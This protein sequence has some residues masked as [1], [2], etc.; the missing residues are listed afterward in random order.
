MLHRSRSHRGQGLAEYGL[1]I[2]MILGI[3]VLV[4]PTIGLGYGYIN[5]S[6]SS[7]INSAIG[8]GGDNGGGGNNPTPTPNGAAPTGYATDVSV[9]NSLSYV[10]GTHWDP[11]ADVTVTYSGTLLGDFAVG[12]NGDSDAYTS[13]YLNLTD[14]G[15]YTLLFTSGTKSATYTVNVSATALP[16]ARADDT[17]VGGATNLYAGDFAPNANITVTYTSGPDSGQ[18]LGTFQVDA[19]GGTTDPVPMTVDSHL[20]PGDYNLL[21]SAGSQTA[22]TVLGIEAPVGSGGGTV[23][24]PVPIEINP[25]PGYSEKITGT[26]FCPGTMVQ[27]LY[28]GNL[29]GDQVA[30]DSSGNVSISVT[31]PSDAVGGSDHTL[32]LRGT[33]DCSGNSGEVTSPGVHIHITIADPCSD[34][35]TVMTDYSPSYPI[36]QAAID[37]GGSGQITGQYQITQCADSRSLVRVDVTMSF[38]GTDLSN[39]VESGLGVPMPGDATTTDVEA[40]FSTCTNHDFT[41]APVVGTVAI[42]TDTMGPTNYSVAICNDRMYPIDSA[43]QEVSASIIGENTGGGYAGVVH[44]EVSYRSW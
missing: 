39:V 7:A 32:S 11:N 37:Q 6:V 30:A 15:S 4:V 9:D 3:M 10:S 40:N 18:A 38:S 20:S 16:W 5:S 26:G 14:V 19:S 21:F 24:P 33:T 23:P 2:A 44:F 29:T 35:G 34:P 13:M 28:D 41:G 1:L 8:G 22:A 42:T 31:I 17:S 12:A 43:S 25:A 36:V 27:A